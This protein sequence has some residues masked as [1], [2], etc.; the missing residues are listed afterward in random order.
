[1][2]SIR[3][4][5][6]NKFKCTFKLPPSPAQKDLEDKA[7]K[8]AFLKPPESSNRSLIT[9]GPI[10]NAET[11][12]QIRVRSLGPIHQ[13]LP[14]SPKKAAKDNNSDDELM[15]SDNYRHELSQFAM[16]FSRASYYEA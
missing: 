7:R 2:Q 15:Q 5:P 8:L 11:K 3:T 14:E 13:N 10:S 9:P 12:T 16:E 4:R 1:M 6:E